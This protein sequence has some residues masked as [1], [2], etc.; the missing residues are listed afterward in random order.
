MNMLTNAVSTEYAGGQLLQSI[1]EGIGILTF[2]NPEKLNA[3][4]VEMAAGLAE[5]L[6]AMKDDPSVRVLIL[7]GAGEKAFI[8]GGDIS[9]FDKTRP[10]AEVAAKSAEKFRERQALLANFPK[11]TISMIRGYCL[12]G[13]LGVALN[14]DMRFAAHGSRFGI[15]AARLGIAYGFEGLQ[16]LMSL[17]GPSRARLILFTGIR[18]S[19][20]EALAFGLI[21]RLVAPEQL[22]TETLAIAKQISQNAPL[23][24][25]AAKTTIGEI[26][27]DPDRRDMRAIAEIATA[28]MDSEDFREGRRA[29]MDK[30]TPKFVGR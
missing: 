29:F 16:R 28:C 15:P 7:T 5:A 14:T 6:T 11:P 27:K 26:L 23:A 20:E 17:V 22:W 3:I 9:Q 21:D 2:N 13:G 10:N 4:S 8:S 19:A 24:I 25:S 30:R 12:G 1:G 18:F